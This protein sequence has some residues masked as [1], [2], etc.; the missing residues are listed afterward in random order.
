MPTL[1]IQCSLKAMLNYEPIPTFEET[2]EEH[3]RRVHPDP[4]ATRRERDE[5]GKEL[6]RRLQND[7]TK[8]K[9]EP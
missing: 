1:C 3:Q 7:D 6:S 2:P 8:R 9:E 5:M 4:E